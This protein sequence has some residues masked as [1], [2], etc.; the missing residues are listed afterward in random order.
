M[1]DQARRKVLKTLAYGAVLSTGV[2]STAVMA[3]STQDVSGGLKATGVT[4]A[5]SGISNVSGVTIFQQGSGTEQS[6]TLMNL[7]NE[8]I[9]L[10]QLAPISVENVR[11]SQRIKVN[12]V[13]SN[14]GLVLAAGRRVS[15]ELST[16]SVDLA[17]MSSEH[18]AFNGSVMSC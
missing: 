5:A 15:F 17:S 2:V 12:S 14:S 11:G 8:P 10:H 1:T 18:S 6:V 7:T 4:Q 9:Y 3:S 16:P 13:S